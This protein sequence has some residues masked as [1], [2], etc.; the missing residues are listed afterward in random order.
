MYTLCWSPKGGSGTTV[1]ASTLAV[2]AA[3]RGPTVAIDLGGDVV[4]ALGAD[5]AESAGA[6]DWL[7]TSGAPAA[8]LW[9][10]AQPCAVDDDLDLRVVRAGAMPAGERLVELASER[11]AA[12]AASHDAHVV[13]D[14]G[15]VIPDGPL[16]QCAA[17]ALMIIRPCYL[18]MRRACAV[19]TGGS[20]VVLIT[21][22]GRA[23]GRKDVERGLG[24][25]VVAELPWD[26]A[27]AR[28]VDAGLL[29]CRVPTGAARALGGLVP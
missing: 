12:A 2:I 24:G 20:D 19:G 15:H 6:G 18:A 7:C 28:A 8:R 4:A 10:L 26:P 3:R 14:A 13:I 17:R 22:P 11:L 23:L 16:L 1:V 27:V 25:P 21:E 29:R 9:Q 5:A